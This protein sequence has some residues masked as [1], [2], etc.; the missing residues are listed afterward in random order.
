MNLNKLAEQAHKIATDR[1]QWKDTEIKDV[2]LVLVEEL[3]EATK[4]HREGYVLEI[5]NGSILID[6]KSSRQEIDQCA[7][8]IDFE[9]SYEVLIKDSFQD[10]LADVIITVLSICHE[11]KIDIDWH[12]KNKMRFNSI[13]GK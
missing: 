6:S 10:E 11:M 5:D 8:D 2:L 1:G 13:R 3:A 4:A 12:L 7:G 9:C